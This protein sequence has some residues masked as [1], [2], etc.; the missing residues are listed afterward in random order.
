MRLAHMLLVTAIAAS[1]T[2]QG[3]NTI[4]RFPLKHITGQHA[5][6]KVKMNKLE[7]I[8]YITFDPSQNLLVVRGTPAGIKLVRELVAKIDVPGR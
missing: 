2:A 1:I 8:D 3:T 6:E 4:A 7:G 5:Y